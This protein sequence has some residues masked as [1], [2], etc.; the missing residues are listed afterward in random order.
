M[1]GPKGFALLQRINVWVKNVGVWGS[2]T[3]K[4]FALFF[5]LDVFPYFLSLISKLFSSFNSSVVSFFC[6]Y[7]YPTSLVPHSPV[8]LLSFSLPLLLGLFH[9]PILS[10]SCILPSGL[11]SSL[12]HPHLLPRVAYQSPQCHDYKGSERN[13]CPCR[14][15]SHWDQATTRGCE[16]VLL[17]WL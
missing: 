11:L 6:H 17:V 4:L 12:S 8:C 3:K 5:P 10:W 16:P 7:V 1:A 9:C 13:S 2:K 15:A 14:S